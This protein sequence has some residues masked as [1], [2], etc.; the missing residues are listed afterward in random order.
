MEFKIT[1]DEDWADM[2]IHDCLRYE[3][4]NFVDMIELS[5][6]YHLIQSKLSDWITQTILDDTTFDTYDFF[7]EVSNDK[8]IMDLIRKVYNPVI[9]E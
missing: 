8:H 4:G 2:Y 3:K 1:L 5:I 6:I 7:N 9:D